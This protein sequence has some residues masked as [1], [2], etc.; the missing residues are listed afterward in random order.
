[1]LGNVGLSSLLS[2]SE[3]LRGSGWR[4]AVSPASH[5]KKCTGAVSP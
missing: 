3:G 5:P 4:S 1:M 2:R